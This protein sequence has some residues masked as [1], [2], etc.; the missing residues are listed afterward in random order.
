MIPP[1]YA[2]KLAALTARADDGRFALTVRPGTGVRYVPHPLQ[3]VFAPVTQNVVLLAWDATY[4]GSPWGDG[5]VCDAAQQV[6][7]TS[8]LLDHA[9]RVFDLVDLRRSASGMNSVPGPSINMP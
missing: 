4:K 2:A 6:P 1:T 8:A 3:A 7:A 9:S 5:L